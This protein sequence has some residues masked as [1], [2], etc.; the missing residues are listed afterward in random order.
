MYFLKL[1]NFQW[2]LISVYIVMSMFFYNFWFL[3][4][5]Q[6]LKDGSMKMFGKSGTLELF[7]NNCEIVVMIWSTIKYE[8]TEVLQ[9]DKYSNEFAVSILTDTPFLLHSY[10]HHF[11]TVEKRFNGSTIT[12]QSGWAVSPTLHLYDTSDIFVTFPMYPMRMMALIY[13]L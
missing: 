2:I 9:C 13:I 12:T 8:V 6:K 1:E 3:V 10:S 5:M 7:L 4:F 11:I